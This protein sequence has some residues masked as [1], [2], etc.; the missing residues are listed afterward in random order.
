MKRFLINVLGVFFSPLLFTL[1]LLDVFW[2]I[3]L[4]WEPL[5]SVTY[6]SIRVLYR[7]SNGL[8]LNLYSLIVSFACRNK[9]YEQAGLFVSPPSK[10]IALK[11]LSRYGYQFEQNYFH[12]PGDICE[13]LA[14]ISVR[15]DFYN[16]NQ[17]SYCNL[18]EAAAD[19]TRLLSRFFYNPSDI[20]CIPEFL[21]CVTDKRINTIA[22]SYLGDSFALVG[23]N[24]W[25]ILPRP[26]LL[27]ENS[28]QTLDE[29]AS[30]QAQLFHYD[31]D[32]PRFLKIFI[33]ISS[34][35]VDSAAF[36]YLPDTHKNIPKLK[37]KDKRLTIKMLENRSPFFFVA[38]P[39]SVLYANTLGLHRD[40]DPGDETRHVLQLEFS[41]S[42]YGNPRTLFKLPSNI[43]DLLEQA[44]LNAS[45]TKAQ[46]KSIL[47]AL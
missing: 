4:R 18:N 14:K 19:P 31:C 24:A 47:R 33:N 27:N 43:R 32:W 44:Y 1:L 30:C 9:A 46:C 39:G 11:N 10:D 6:I 29:I 2:G 20:L 25:A 36:E 3:F 41:I 23:I 16:S 8:I 13:S 5:L 15:S 42:C 35:S 17:S 40:G 37:F 22:K 12:F 28:L 45:F 21:N 34:S 7:L 26:K 38:D